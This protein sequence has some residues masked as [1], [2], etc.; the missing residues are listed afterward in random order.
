MINNN[1]LLDG[2]QIY[3]FSSTEELLDSI[4]DE[5][6]ILVAVNYQK[7]VHSTKEIKNIIKN[8]IGYIEGAWLSIAL[9]L[10]GYRNAIQIPGCELWLKI[11]KHYHDSKT[12]YLIG[13]KSL[14]IEETVKKL[15]LEFPNINILNYHDGY[16]NEIEKEKIFFDLNEKKPDIV[17]V[18][19]GSPK[20][21]LFMQ[22]MLAIHP[23]LYQGLGGSFD[24]YTNNGKN[25]APQW[26]LDHKLEWLYYTINSPSHF[27]R[28]RYLPKYLKIIFLSKPQ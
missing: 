21:E 11:I 18:A 20:Q 16:F 1:I 25:R 3:P 28:L 4:K 2:I 26:W 8:N 15:K 27:I 10:K 13:G 12:F 9:K 23:A 7:V 17:F 6:K 24:V 22:E 14:V 5:K 19:M